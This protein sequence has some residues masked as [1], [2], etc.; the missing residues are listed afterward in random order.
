[1]TIDFGCDPKRADELVKSVFQDIGALREKGPT[2]REVSDAREALLRRH[3]T[4][5]ARNPSLVGEISDRLE[6]GE[7]L[8][9]YFGLPRE[10]RQ[11]TPRMV[12][13]AARRYLDPGRYVRV[14]LYPE[15]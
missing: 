12:Q 2:D 4:S 6:N 1:V 8:S 10:Y 15:R 5:L 3:E 11:L 7:D 13:D 9:T 14:T